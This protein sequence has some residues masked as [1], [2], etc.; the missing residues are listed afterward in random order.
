MVEGRTTQNMM[1]GYVITFLLM[2]RSARAR[3]VFHPINF[4]LGL[5]F[6][7]FVIEISSHFKYLPIRIGTG[8]TNTDQ[9][10][11]NVVNFQFYRSR[12]NLC[13]KLRP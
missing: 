4:L 11:D 1:V 8:Y 12:P 5:L 10:F 13:Y 9:Y 2:N 7:S 6:C 3:I